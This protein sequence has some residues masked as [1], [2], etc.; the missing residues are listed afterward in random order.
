MRQGDGGHLRSA[1][2]LP[3]I[4]IRGSTAFRRRK[5]LATPKAEQDMNPSQKRCLEQP[6]SCLVS[7]P[8]VTWTLVDLGRQS[9]SVGTRNLADII[10]IARAFCKRL[11]FHSFWSRCLHPFMTSACSMKSRGSWKNLQ[12][13]AAGVLDSQSQRMGT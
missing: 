12:N 13:G 5:H 9:P 7:T 6:K 8:P 3:E 4:D 10:L 2:Q 11:S 1:D